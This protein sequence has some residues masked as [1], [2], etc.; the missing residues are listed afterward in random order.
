M[1][2]AIPLPARSLLVGVLLLATACGDSRPPGVADSSSAKEAVGS[3]PTT[4]S[5][6]TDATPDV[7]LPS[8]GGTTS[9][10]AAAAP[11]ADDGLPGEPFDYDIPGAGDLMAVVGVAHDDVLNLRSLPGADQPIVET[12][13][14]LTDD[15]VTTGRKRILP[16]ESGIWAEVTHRTSAGWVNASYL[17]YLGVVDDW[18]S[19]VVEANGGRVPSGATMEALG[20]AVTDALV[21]TDP[22]DGPRLV[23]VAP[24]TD[25]DRGEVTYDVVGLLDDSQ[26]GVRLHLFGAPQPGGGFTLAAAEATG[27]CRRGVNDARACI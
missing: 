9:S 13:A 26:L 25:G 22:A 23:Q 2:P 12:L 3:T 5:A 7:T 14:P 24:A 20:R 18:T 19:R 21:Q 17:G 4:V 6:T 1:F 16:D 11:L 27:L 10:S 8:S 15:V